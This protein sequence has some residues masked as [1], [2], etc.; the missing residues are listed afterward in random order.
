MAVGVLGDRNKLRTAILDAV[1][2]TGVEIKPL[3]RQLNVSSSHLFGL[4][5]EELDDARREHAERVDGLLAPV[6]QARARMLGRD[7]KRR[8]QQ[9]AE[10]RERAVQNRNGSGPAAG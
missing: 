1:R 10:L 5:G 7:V 8:R 9:L 4:L 6:R 3:A 2:E